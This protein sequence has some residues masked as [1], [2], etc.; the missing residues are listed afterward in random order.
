MTKKLYIF[1]TKNK[2]IVHQ[3]LREN[4]YLSWSYTSAMSQTI[5]EKMGFKSFVVVM[6]IGQEDNDMLQAKLIIGGSD[7]LDSYLAAVMDDP[8]QD[9]QKAYCEVVKDYFKNACVNPTPP[10]KETRCGN[11]FRDFFTHNK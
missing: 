4:D 11:Q 3:R 10:E 9:A 2:Q 6:D 1:R 5:S 8:E 7:R